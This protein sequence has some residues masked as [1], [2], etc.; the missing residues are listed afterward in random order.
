MILDQSVYVCPERIGS[1][2]RV[3]Q[4]R[5][6]FR[7]IARRWRG[8]RGDVGEVFVVFLE[9]PARRHGVKRPRRVRSGGIAWPAAPEKAQGTN[10]EPAVATQWFNCSSLVENV[11]Y[12]PMCSSTCDGPKGVVTTNGKGGP[13]PDASVGHQAPRGHCVNQHVRAWNN[14]TT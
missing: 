1:E 8:Q 14:Q 4:L 6:G 10:R 5:V 11:T 9:A 3:E 2:Q 7:E 13:V 12:T